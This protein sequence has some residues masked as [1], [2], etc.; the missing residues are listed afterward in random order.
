MGRFAAQVPSCQAIA[1]T[2]APAPC[3]PRRPTPTPPGHAKIRTHALL[4]TT[5]WQSF[6]RGHAQLCTECKAPHQRPASA[7]LYTGEVCSFAREPDQMRSCVRRAVRTVQQRRADGRGA[8]LCT[9]AALWDLSGALWPGV[10]RRAAGGGVRS[11]APCMRSVARQH[12]AERT[13]KGRIPSEL[14]AQW[15]RRRT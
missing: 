5:D 7:E 3:Q 10:P 14:M 6:A 15:L 12:R 4:Y 8:N 9:W 1:P 11:C 2:P 13:S